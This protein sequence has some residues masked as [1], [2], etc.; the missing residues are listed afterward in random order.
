MVRKLQLEVEKWQHMVCG[1][2][3]FSISADQQEIPSQFIFPR[4]EIGEQMLL[5]YLVT[6]D[7]KRKRWSE[8]RTGIGWVGK[9]QGDK[10]ESRPFRNSETFRIERFNYFSYAMRKNKWV[11]IKV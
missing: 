9:L 4:E 2:R 8:K 7:C 1:S 5:A 6:T 3:I 11:L 10:R